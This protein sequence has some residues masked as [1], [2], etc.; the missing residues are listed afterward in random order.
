MLLGMERTDPSRLSEGRVT[1]HAV[2]IAHAI[3]TT[4]ATA[5]AARAHVHARGR[6]ERPVRVGPGAEPVTPQRMVSAEGLLR[7]AK[8][9]HMEDGEG[10]PLPMPATA[11]TWTDRDQPPSRGVLTRTQLSDVDTLICLGGDLLPPEVM[12][13]VR[14][15][16]AAKEASTTRDERRRAKE[17][18][19]RQRRIAERGSAEASGM[20]EWP[21]PLS[22]CLAYYGWGSSDGVSYAAGPAMK[23]RHLLPHAGRESGFGRAM[24]TGDYSIRQCGSEPLLKRLVGDW[25]EV[26]GIPNDGP[27]VLLV[28]RYWVNCATHRS[29]STCQSIVPAD[30]AALSQWRNWHQLTQHAH[31]H[32]VGRACREDDDLMLDEGDAWGAAAMAV[33]WLYL[34]GKQVEGVHAVHSSTPI[35]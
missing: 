19:L 17:E 16:R 12:A 20:L 14:F 23:N 29:G 5:T 11:S 8:G 18:A 3:D 4:T 6:L 13:T 15:R 33:P 30:E 24:D 35:R 9:W 1:M 25:R 34:D 28:Q 7:W 10:N 21:R 31:A 27:A 22:G 2:R 26:A 32:G